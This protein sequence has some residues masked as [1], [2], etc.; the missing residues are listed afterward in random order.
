M[1]RS[2]DGFGQGKVLASPLGMAIVAATAASGHRIVP[3][4]INGRDTEVVGP[5]VEL[6]GA[7]YERLRPM[8]RAVVAEGTATAIADQGEVYGKTGEA[9]VAGGSHAW[10]AGYRDDIAFA[11]LVVMG[12]GSEAAVR[13]TREFLAGIPDGYRP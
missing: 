3:Q 9:E 10:F 5:E 2:E 7:V 8:M 1:P 4:L 13:V 12:G 6:D 11:T